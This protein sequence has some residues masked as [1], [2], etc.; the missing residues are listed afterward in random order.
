MTTTLNDEPFRIAERFIVLRKKW[1]TRSW[2]ETLLRVNELL[3]TPLIALFMLFLATTDMF[4]ILSSASMVYKSWSEWIEYCDLRLKVNDMYFK[5][6]VAG[7]PFIVTNDP[8][9]MPY[10][11]ADGVTRTASPDWK[12]PQTH[13]TH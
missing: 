2:V 13:P 12:H 9:Y 11:W 7:G 10:V 8:T 4:A 1:S 6:M 3:L 5:T